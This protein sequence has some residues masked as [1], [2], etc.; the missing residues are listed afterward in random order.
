LRKQVV[1]GSCESKMQAV[2]QECA[3]HNSVIL[4]LRSIIPNQFHRAM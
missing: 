3:V 4:L 2:N 1:K